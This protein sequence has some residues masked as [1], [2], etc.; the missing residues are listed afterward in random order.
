MSRNN[1]ERFDQKNDPKKDESQKSKKI[2]IEKW[3]ILGALLV[4]LM[5]LFVIPKYKAYAKN[6]EVLAEK[7]SYNMALPDEMSEETYL[8]ELKRI[9]DQLDVSKKSLPENIDT[10]RLYEVVAKKAESCQLGLI[11]VKFEQA[12][13][14]IDT[15]I[16]DRIEKGFSEKEEKNI[17]VSDGKILTACKFNVVCVGNDDQIIDFLNE[18]NQ[19][20]PIIRVLTY[21]IEGDVTNKK[22]VT[23]KLESFGIQEEDRFN[24]NVGDEK[25]TSEKEEGV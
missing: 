10:I 18:L 6:K 13:A 20:Q 17:R 7:I 15:I 25:F 12:D 21:E 3:I 1:V 22:T 5:A 9:G 19:C 2:R 8:E 23:L 4:I 16:G 14:H 24:I 11:S